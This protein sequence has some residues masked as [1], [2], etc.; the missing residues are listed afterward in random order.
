MVRIYFEKKDSSEASEKYVN[1]YFWS[2]V[3]AYV[4]G[5][6]GIIGVIFIT[7]G[8]LYIL[9]TILGVIF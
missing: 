4:L 8:A 2:I 3:K 1:I 9:L 7:W 5:W 6:C